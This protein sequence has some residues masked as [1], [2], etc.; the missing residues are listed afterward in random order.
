MAEISSKSHLT[1]QVLA[2]LFLSWLISMLCFDAVHPFL[3][4][5]AD[6]TYFVCSNRDK[7]LSVSHKKKKKNLKNPDKIM[8]CHSILMKGTD[9]YSFCCPITADVQ[10]RCTLYQQANSAEP[11]L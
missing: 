7:N 5:N 3:A 8:Q 2:A 10:T 4:V 6:F 11:F 1:F 9:G